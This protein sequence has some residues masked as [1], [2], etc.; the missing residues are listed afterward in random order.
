[1]AILPPQKRCTI[2]VRDKNPLKL[3]VKPRAKPEPTHA[4]APGTS[5]ISTLR[6]IWM[7]TGSYLPQ[8]Y[9]GLQ[10]PK[11][12][13]KSLTDVLQQLCKERCLQE[14]VDYVRNTNDKVT[15]EEEEEAGEEFKFC[16]KEMALP[17]DGHLQK[18]SSAIAQ[19]V[20]EAKVQTE[21]TSYF[22]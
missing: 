4:Q 11:E 12:A 18:F 17:L 21:I 1:M 9:T 13:K 3:T 16:K 7:P 10:H 19:E 5:F 8:L 22:K 6:K 15:K 14:I 2:H 20:E